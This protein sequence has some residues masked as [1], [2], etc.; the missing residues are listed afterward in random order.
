MDCTGQVVQQRSS[1][2]RLLKITIIQR[3][4]TTNLICHNFV[5]TN[6][7]NIS[8]YRLHEEMEDFFNYMSPTEEEHSVRLSVVHRIKSVIHSLWVRFKIV[9]GRIIYVRSTHLYC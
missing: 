9:I 5:L 2:V 7:N 1:W 8:C 3:T 4:I 6:N